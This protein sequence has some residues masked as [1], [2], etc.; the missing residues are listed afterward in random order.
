MRNMLSYKLLGPLE[1]AGDRGSTGPATPKIGTV[2]ALLLCQPNRV[3]STSTISDELWGDDPPRSASTT[4]QTYVYQLRKALRQLDGDQRA[5]VPLCTRPPGYMLSAEPGNVDV[6]AFEQLARE[7]RDLVESDGPADA[8]EP[9][10]RA[11]DLWRGPAFGNVQRGP[12]LQ[13]HAAHLDEQL[14]RVRELR[15]QAGFMLGR[16]RELVGEL[17]L[18]A[19]THPLNEWV[20]DRLIVALCHAG[21]RADALRAYQRLRRNLG[22]VGIEP[23]PALQEREHEVL[24]ADLAVADLADLAFSAAR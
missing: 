21:R 17:T 2:L 15:I 3:V 5:E 9:F 24:N 7:G 20:H 22:E 6:L 13:A 16:H 8:L 11:L 4:I 14:L 10:G 18:L 12:V 23:S 1:I 19:G